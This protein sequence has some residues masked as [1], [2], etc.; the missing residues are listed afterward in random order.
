MDCAG[1]IDTLGG[2][3]LAL[4]TPCRTG[5]GPREAPFRPLRAIPAPGQGTRPGLRASPLTIG[6]AMGLPH[7]KENMAAVPLHKV[8]EPKCSRAGQ[9]TDGG[10]QTAALVCSSDRADSAGRLP[11][12]KRAPPTCCRP[13]G[14]RPRRCSS[15]RHG[16]VR[17]LPVRVAAPRLAGAVGGRLA[18]GS[19]GCGH[20]RGRCCAHF[21]RRGETPH[22]HAR[23]GCHSWRPVPAGP[24]GG[25]RGSWGRHSAGTAA[26]ALL[27]P[28]FASRALPVPWPR[29]GPQPSAVARYTQ[30]CCSLCRDSLLS[31]LRRASQ[32]SLAVDRPID[33]RTSKEPTVLCWHPR[34]PTLIIGWHDGEQALRV[35]CAC[36][37]LP[38]PGSTA[39]RWLVTPEGEPDVA[40]SVCSSLA[41]RPGHG[42]ASGDTI[43]PCN[44]LALLFFVWCIARLSPPVPCGC[45]VRRPRPERFRQP[46]WQGYR[47]RGRRGPQERNRGH[48]GVARGWPRAV[49]GLCGRSLRVAL[50]RPRQV[51]EAA[52]VSLGRQRVGAHKVGVGPHPS[53]R[54]LGWHR[55][56]HGLLRRHGRRLAGVR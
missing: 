27:H 42:C 22:A 49:N 7:S 3:K 5:C 36:A 30:Q 45:V 10:S 53:A 40:S 52:H 44:Q 33:S 8:P 28:F 31:L 13:E 26:E 56:A 29:S 51:L 15:L 48:C 25:V 19:A 38:F 12:S 11:N 41:S 9:P 20:W 32:G 24:V 18:S 4:Q 50:R 2:T 23:H 55:V 16:L 17:V 1:R 43:V 35:Q 47:V 21:R 14:P 6:S 46:G 34:E 39:S 37:G 54:R